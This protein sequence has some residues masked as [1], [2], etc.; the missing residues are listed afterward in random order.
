MEI[1]RLQ[2]EH[3]LRGQEQID[4]HAKGQKREKLSLDTPKTTWGKVKRY[5]SNIGRVVDAV[6]SVN[7][8]GIIGTGSARTGHQ[9]TDVNVEAPPLEIHDDT[10]RRTRAF[11]PGENEA[12]THLSPAKTPADSTKKKEKT[13]KK[14]PYPRR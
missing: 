10:L 7:P 12:K 13:R 3:E 9:A 6:I 5:F 2:Q 4:A 11:T 1:E 8:A 14:N